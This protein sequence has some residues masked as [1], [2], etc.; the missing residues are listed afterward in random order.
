[1]PHRASQRQHLQPQ[2]SPRVA[3]SGGGTLPCDGIRE[4]ASSAAVPCG[5]LTAEASELGASC[6]LR[7]LLRTKS[8][9]VCPPPSVRRCID[10]SESR[11]CHHVLLTAICGACCSNAQRWR[12]EQQ[13]RCARL[14][15]SAAIDDLQQTLLQLQLEGSAEHPNRHQH[16]LHS[17]VPQTGVEPQAI[18]DNASGAGIHACFTLAA[19]QKA[20]AG[21]LQSQVDDQSLVAEPLPMYAPLTDRVKWLGCGPDRTAAERFASSL[22]ALLRQLQ[23]MATKVA[24][25]VSGDDTPEPHQ[26]LLVG[27]DTE[28][29]D[30]ADRQDAANAA[31][32]AE[33]GSGA[34]LA[35]AA[36][37]A[38]LQLAVTQPLGAGAD[39]DTDAAD[40]AGR[41][42][43]A[44]VVDCSAPTPELR[45]LVRWLLFGSSST[46]VVGAAA[47]SPQLVGFAFAHDIPRL[48][49]LADMP[50]TAIVHPVLDLQKVAMDVEAQLIRHEQQQCGGGARGRR[51]P[52]RDTPGLG[53]LTSSWLG[54]RL[55]KEQ[56]CSVRDN[57]LSACCYSD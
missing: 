25:A 2:T 22:T 1:M 45:A 3:Q 24:E 34:K 35:R 14:L 42:S 18:I 12:H 38:V 15:P 9:I 48:L 44:W 41:A 28:W 54:K 5:I 20:R 10:V 7:A 17:R 53:R 49:T 46:A 11:H 13:E 55:N 23:A 31:I 26:R 6:W 29:G 50:S 43:A 8:S 52:H 27:V 37:P 4:C 47:A 36:A 30:V 19:L 16:Q 32:A 40:S 51:K 57:P 21:K 56:Q 33:E 39:A